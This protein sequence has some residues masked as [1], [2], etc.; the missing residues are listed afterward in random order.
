MDIIAMVI[1]TFLYVLLIALVIR[2]LMSW[3]P[4]AGNNA[5]GQALRQITEPVLDPVR[6]VLPSTGMIDF[7]TLIVIIL[8]YVMINVVNQAAAS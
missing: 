7:S 2:A 8:I 3:F 6:R 1:T 5:F 4:G